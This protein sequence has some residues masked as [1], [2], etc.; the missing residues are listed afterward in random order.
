[1]RQISVLHQKIH[2]GMAEES[3]ERKVSNCDEKKYICMV[4]AKV[5]RL[6][7]KIM[8]KCKP[9]RPEA[10]RFAAAAP[11]DTDIKNNPSFHFEKMTYMRK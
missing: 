3:A 5:C 2:D 11:G 10:C 1:M 8:N 6:A 9:A 4:Y 7:A